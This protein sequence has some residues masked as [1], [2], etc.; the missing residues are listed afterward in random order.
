MNL[1]VDYLREVIT[2][3]TWSRRKFARI[4]GLSIATISRI[5]NNKRNAGR[6]SIN[7]IRKVL[8]DEPMEKLFY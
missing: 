1:N 7:A 2:R 5:L 4:T 8:K 6:K 3:R